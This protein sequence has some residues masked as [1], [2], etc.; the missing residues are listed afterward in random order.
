[1]QSAS[2]PNDRFSER[3]IENLITPAS[4]V[5]NSIGFQIL[6]AG[7]PITLPDGSTMTL[8][9]DYTLTGSMNIGLTM[10]W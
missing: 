6:L 5:E 8:P 9:A 3:N 1:L 7:Y 10:C 4:I 2:R